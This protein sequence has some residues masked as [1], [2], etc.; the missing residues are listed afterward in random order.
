MYDPQKHHRQSLRLD[1]Y[2]YS[3]PGFYFITAC[4]HDRQC[5]FGSVSGGV[6]HL[7]AYGDIVRAAWDDLPNH[8]PHVEL[9]EFVVMPNHAHGILCLTDVGA[10]FQPALPAPSKRH[11]LG[12]I[13][14]AFKTYSARRINERRGVKAVPVWQRDFYEHVIRNHEPLGAF[15]DYI[16]SNPE[17]WEHD[18]ENPAGSGTDDVE[19]WVETVKAKAGQAQRASAGG[20][21]ETGR[22]GHRP[23]PTASSVGQRRA[24]TRGAPRGDQAEG[25]LETRPYTAAR[26]VS[27]SGPAIRIGHGYD[28]HRLQ[29][30]GRLVVGGVEVAQGVSPVAHSDGDVVL[31][32]VVDALLGAMAWGDIGEHFS[33]TDPQWKGASSSLFVT[34]IY[35]RV[36][37]A[38]YQVQNLD[39]TVLAERPRLKPFKRPIADLLAGLL[40]VTPD[41][42]N[43]KAGTNE[44]CDAVG[45]G[46]AIAAH[47]VVLL[48][49]AD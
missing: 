32:A 38:R 15:R 45:R 23:A 2:D 48:A 35:E 18:K 29:P 16:R 21:P 39:V 34:T 31:H 24:L 43:V 12:E 9:D 46:E 33:N 20:E 10:G 11:S 19:A 28:L 1:G 4:A 40:H 8:F 42:V 41:R 44:G 36:R 22:A 13:V 47:A 6:M 5:L 3:S 27:G 30:G 26:A 17:R 49:R 7:S 37:A 14:G 25:G